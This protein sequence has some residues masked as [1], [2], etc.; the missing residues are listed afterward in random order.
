MLI[1]ISSYIGQHQGVNMKKTMKEYNE[2]K[3]EFM[4]ERITGDTALVLYNQMLD[5][6]N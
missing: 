4:V 2:D 5:M 3:D 1:S 6:Y